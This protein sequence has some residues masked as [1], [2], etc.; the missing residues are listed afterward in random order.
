[1]S[2]A[3]Q[4]DGFPSEGDISLGFAKIMPELERMGA[5]PAQMQQAKASLETQG[6]LKRQA[7]R[8][9]I[10]ENIQQKIDRGE[11]TILDIQENAPLL[12]EELSQ[13]LLD[14]LKPGSSAQLPEGMTQKDVKPE[15]QRALTRKLIQDPNVD[16]SKAHESI[17]PATRAAQDM[18]LNKYRTYVSQGM[19]EKLAAKTAI[20]DVVQKIDTDG[21]ND[22]FGTLAGA[23]G[24]AGSTLFPAFTRST[25]MGN[26]APTNNAAATNAAINAVNAGKVPLNQQ[27]FIDATQAAKIENQIITGKQ[28]ELPGYIYALSTRLGVTPE[29]L[30]DAQLEA[31]GKT[32]RL[33]GLTP[34]TAIQNT[35]ADSTM[36]AWIPSFPTTTNV[37]ASIAMTGNFP[38]EFQSG[39]KGWEQVKAAAM[40][41]DGA[42][43]E[44]TAAM[45]AAA[46]N[47]GMNEAYI[48]DPEGNKMAA[49]SP[50]EYV[51][52]ANG[53]I[54][55]QVKE[56]GLSSG[57]T[58][59][60]LIQSGALP[61]SM[62]PVL[63]TQGLIDRRP[64]KQV[65]AG[66]SATTELTV[67]YITGSMTHG[68]ESTA[69]EHL[70]VDRQDNPNTP[71][72]E[73]LTYIDQH[74]KMMN[75]SILIE[76]GKGT[77]KFLTPREWVDYTAK[78]GYPETGAQRY[79]APRDGGS[80]QHK[81]Y[82]F[83][84][85]AGSKIKLR[86]GAR[87]IKVIP[88][89]SNGDHVIIQF[90]DGS[91]QR[92]LHGKFSGVSY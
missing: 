38:R 74:D 21:E 17:F 57:Q 55:Q 27:K 40:N 61:Q 9:V 83:R 44:L 19:T 91:R 92:L 22:T 23:E 86:N 33:N 28:L 25:D 60:E 81:G 15:I 37:N 51:E 72:N 49:G 50:K 5:T 20:S 31:Y 34:I 53:I 24:E 48:T 80:R 62:L 35:A 75:E 45:W 63:T 29:Q 90:K 26:W 71:E 76:T 8:T 16:S 13:S 14:E 79:G 54:E 36:K 84:S 68:V 70:H 87:I 52:W 73:S 39:T 42:Y 88:G 85:E 1:M 59:R 77:N 6:A 66:S 58:Y 78:L 56:G 3:Q 47:Y 18:Y 41:T 64:A 82:D 69:G 7:S 89:T 10:A 65:I 46:T 30:I 4:E 32:T 67:A 43:P 12:G 2:V 11:A